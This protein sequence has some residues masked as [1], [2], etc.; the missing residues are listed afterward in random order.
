MKRERRK[1]GKEIQERE[2]AGRGTKGRAGKHLAETQ[3]QS[4]RGG[5]DNP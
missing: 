4:R 2:E 3:T 5:S 1:K